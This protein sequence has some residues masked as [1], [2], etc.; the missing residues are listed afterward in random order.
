[1]SYVNNVCY[2]NNMSY[3]HYMKSKIKT[4]YII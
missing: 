3:V 2:V 1:M 4:K